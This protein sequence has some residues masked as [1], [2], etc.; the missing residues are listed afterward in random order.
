MVY[1]D[2]EKREVISSPYYYKSY[3]SGNSVKR[4]YIGGKKEFQEYLRN[5]RKVEQ[6]LKSLKK[7]TM[8]IISILLLFSLIILFLAFNEEF[9][10]PINEKSFYLL[11]LLEKPFAG[12]V[13]VEISDE[14]IKFD[15][16]ILEIKNSPV[17]NNSSSKNKRMD[18][19]VEGGLRLYFDL[20]NYSEFVEETGE[21]LVDSGLVKKEEILGSNE[22]INDETNNSKGNTKS[23]DTKNDGES[24]EI[25]EASDLL[26]GSVIDEN[27]NT[28]Q[29]ELSINNINE[30][31]ELTINNLNIKKVK[32]GIDYLNEDKIDEISEKA[33]IEAE[34]FDIKID[35]QAAKK[36]N[37]DYKWG[38]KVKL[39]DLNFI[40]K[41]DVTSDKEISILNNYELR[42]G[43][44]FLSFQDLINE[45][46]TIRIEKPALEIGVDKIVEINISIKN[47]TIIDETLTNKTV[48]KETEKNLTIINETEKEFIENITE[49]LTEA[50][51][52]TQGTEVNLKITNETIKPL[53][54]ETGITGEIIKEVEENKTIEEVVEQPKLVESVNET[55]EKLQETVEQPIS[56]PELIE[57]TKN[58]SS[59]VGITGNVIRGITARVI[60]NFQVEDLEYSNTVSIYIERDFSNTDYKVGDIIYL[61]P[62]LIIKISKAEH[63]DSNRKFIKDIYDYVKERDN[64]WTL[65][66]N[67]E[68]VRVT[69]EQNLT[70]KSDITIYARSADNNSSIEVYKKDDSELITKFENVLEDKEYRVL[71][72]GL[73]GSEKVFDLKVLGSIEFDYIVDPVNISSFSIQPS[74]ETLIPRKY[75]GLEKYL[76]SS[77][78]WTSN[79]TDFHINLTINK[80]SIDFLKNLT[81]TIAQKCSTLE[82]YLKEDYPNFSCL[83][84]NNVTFLSNQIINY[85]RKGIKVIKQG[86]DLGYIN[87]TNNTVNIKIPIS[88]LNNN[89]LIQL[90]ENSLTYIYQNI[91]TVRYEYDTF[92][93]NATLE[94]CDE[95]R[96]NC[97]IGYP[98]LLIVNANT[99]K[100]GAV[101]Q[102]R[103]KD[104]NYRYTWQSTSP[105]LPD[106][107]GYYL[108]GKTTISGTHVKTRTEEKV[109]IKTSDICSNIINSSNSSIIAF[110]PDCT[111]NSYNK[112]VANAT[113]YF[114]E[115]LFKAKWNATTKNITIDPV[116]QINTFSTSES[117]NTN[118]TQESN[119]S[120]LQ[121]NTDVSPYNNLVLYL[122]LDV[123]HT[124]DSN[125]Y[126]YDYTANNNDG[127]VIGGAR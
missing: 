122:P 124:L 55:Q 101:D 18:F 6:P 69:F 119:F 45:G 123:N 30:S 89:D 94:R 103:T 87:I 91:S 88:I 49:N 62:T 63:L 22:I 117:I 41:V 15:K 20:L 111:F 44:N 53:E 40:A 66:N 102:N 46:Y 74:G 59:K 100:F 48:V 92:Q 33:V 61:D 51:N 110:A 85:T 98:D 36:Q 84:I 26:T 83:N 116:Y 82:P 3:R 67:N 2:I 127:K 115:V 95:N 75:Q 38:Y 29:D 11:N 10:V 126:T 56:E 5:K 90:G 57:S 121:I 31:D 39:K 7:R 28:I 99:L 73:E 47:K 4:I 104:E 52:L 35:E 120:H 114:L 60:D 14:S 68:Y 106:N 24:S 71:L 78:N 125:N 54:N 86:I 25:S 17:F 113:H 21:A 58:T 80:T 8:A 107:E 34:N 43:N 96:T 50:E 13:T 64:N 1:Q 93:I 72:T 19:D 32:E 79:G 109:R 65:V 16:S 76:I 97:G 112:A 70:N 108:A 37:V 105:I 23:E 27:Q 81:I 77:K 12:S 118:V 42:I 9:K